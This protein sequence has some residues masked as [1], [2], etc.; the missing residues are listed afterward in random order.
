MGFFN[1]KFARTSFISV[2]PIG[3]VFALSSGGLFTANN[4][5]IKEMDVVVSDAVLV[6][7]VMQ[8]SILSFI[9]LARGEKLLPESTKDRLFTIAQGKH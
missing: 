9:I 2:F 6:R 5:I 3:V 7:C 4:F 1:K 8:I